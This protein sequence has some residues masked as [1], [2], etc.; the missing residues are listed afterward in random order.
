MKSKVLMVVI[1][2]LLAFLTCLGAVSC[3]SDSTPVPS[4]TETPDESTD[5][6]QAPSEDANIYDMA[7]IAEEL[8]AIYYDLDHL[9]VRP[10]IEDD[11]WILNVTLELADIMTLCDQ[12]WQRVSPDSMTDVEVTFLE[13]INHFDDAAD[14]LVKGIDEKN[15]DLINQASA[16]MWL[17]TEILAQVAEL[18]E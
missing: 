8:T 5:V 10:E 18:P 16:E 2:F 7:S 9:L 6:P 12:A 11:D 17:A 15:I 1:T 13:A 4:E 14:L 3:G